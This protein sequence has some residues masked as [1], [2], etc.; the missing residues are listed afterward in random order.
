MLPDILGQIPGGGGK[1]FHRADGLLTPAGESEL[2]RLLNYVKFRA[3]SLRSRL[4]P[5][6]PDREIVEA[7]ERLLDAAELVREVILKANLRLVGSIARRYARNETEFDEFNAEGGVTL[8]GAIEKFDYARGFRFSTYATH[9]VQRQMYRLMARRD[10][11]R[12]RETV[13]SPEALSGV[14]VEHCFPNIDGEPAQVLRRL[15]RI[16]GECLTPREQG[17]IRERFGLNRE[18]CGRTLLE[19]SRELGLSKERVRQIQLQ[20]LRKLREFAAA[21]GVAVEM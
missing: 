4:N 19:I 18:R 16:W 14:G 11:R 15:M 17:I 20:A 12:T 6:R 8:L 7:A 13:V 3:N 10:R 1:P 21:K 2:F 9:A 5:E